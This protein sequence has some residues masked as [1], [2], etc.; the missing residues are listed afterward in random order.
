MEFLDQAQACRPGDTHD[1]FHFFSPSIEQVLIN[2]SACG[3]RLFARL[4]L[5]D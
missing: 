1:V 2:V 4:R 5:W 3:A